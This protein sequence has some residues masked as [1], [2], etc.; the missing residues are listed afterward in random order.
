[1]ERLILYQ[2]LLHNELRNVATFTALGVSLL[3][4][5]ITVASRGSVMVGKGF[6]VFGVLYL[7][8]AN[9]LRVLMI[10]DFPIDVRQ[11]MRGWFLLLKVAGVI[12]ALIFLWSCV[13]LAR[14]P[15]PP[16]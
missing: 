13:V 3:V 7:C 10:R 6:V 8:F 2:G 12:E 5:G 11:R 4:A 15:P 9:A 1:M 14:K 16:G